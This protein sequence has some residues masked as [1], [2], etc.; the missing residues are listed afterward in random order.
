ML[1]LLLLLCCCTTPRLP[2]LGRNNQ[3]VKC[4]LFSLQTT[5]LIHA[6]R[7]PCNTT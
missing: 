6:S 4:L 2:L 5:P 3:H 7:E 1:L